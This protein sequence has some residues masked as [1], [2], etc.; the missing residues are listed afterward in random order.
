MVDM[1]PSL[2]FRA[3]R[4]TLRNVGNQSPAPA[5][6]SGRFPLVQ[7]DIQI[8][9]FSAVCVFASFFSRLMLHGQVGSPG[10]E[11][12]GGIVKISPAYSMETGE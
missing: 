7:L 12:Q 1:G 11:G 2:G 3:A 9:S 6:E 4:L 8:Q 10:A 5:K